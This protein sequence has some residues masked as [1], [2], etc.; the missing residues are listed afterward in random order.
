MSVKES[1]KHMGEGNF[2]K[3]SGILQSTACS[4]RYSPSRKYEGIPHG[5]GRDFGCCKPTLKAQPAGEGLSPSDDETPVIF[6]T[7]PAHPQ[8][9]FYQ[10]METCQPSLLDITSQH[11]KYEQV[12]RQVL[13]TLDHDTPRQSKGQKSGFQL[14]QWA[15]EICHGKM[16]LAEKLEKSNWEIQRFERL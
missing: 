2:E 7:G 10:H 8:R 9:A 13:A 15:H 1:R 4:S 6:S 12:S 11:R 3:F 14:E 5:N 16:T